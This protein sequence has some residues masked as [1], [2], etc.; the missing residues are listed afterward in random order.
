MACRG[1]D[2]TGCPQSALLACGQWVICP[3]DALGRNPDCSKAPRVVSNSWGGA[4]GQTW[5]NDVIKAWNEA[6]IIG[7]FAIGNDGPEC[8]TAGSPGDQPG[9][10]SVGAT[11][12]NDTVASFSS[13]GPKKT[14][15]GTVTPLIVA[16]GAE[17]NSAYHLTDNAYQVLSGTSMATPLAAGVTALLLSK[18]PQLT[19]EEVTQLL[20][21]TTQRNLGSTGSTCGKNAENVYPNDVAGHGRIDANQAFTRLTSGSG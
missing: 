4:G 10:I 1:C 6:G 11:D 7:L 21:P 19:R 18:N 15:D 8:S 9:I 17:I 3:T 20:Y 5:Y 16:P 12:I 2:N 14:P 13:R